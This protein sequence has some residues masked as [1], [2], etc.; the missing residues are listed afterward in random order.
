[1]NFSVRW[2]G[3]CDIIMKMDFKKKRK[4]FVIFLIIVFLSIVLTVIFGLFTCNDEMKICA[5]S[6]TKQLWLKEHAA[7]HAHPY[8]QSQS[9]S[10]QQ[11]SSSNS[12]NAIITNIY[13]ISASS[14]S[15]RSNSYK[16]D[17]LDSHLI[18]LSYDEV[19]ND[20]FQSKF[21]INKFDVMV[22][23]FI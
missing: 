18:G 1:M 5:F 22:S 19:L 13:N 16:H 17:K 3:Q 2:I 21:D 20:D 15:R 12:N 8:Q 9:P 10:H 14:I 7:H 6:S 23:D 11:Q 4:C